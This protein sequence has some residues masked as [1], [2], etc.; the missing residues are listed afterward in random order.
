V[1]KA[2]E[3][4]KE[5]S[6][7]PNG[8]QDFP[9]ELAEQAK[10]ALAAEQ[11]SVD[12]GIEAWKK[13]VQAA[14]AEWP[15]RRELAR[16][17]KQ[18]ERWKNYVDVLSEGVDKGKWDREEDKVPVL[19]EMIEVYRDRLKLTALVAK[20]FDQILTIQPQN[21]EAVDALGA[22]YESIARWPDLI[23]IL[24]RK[25]EVVETPVDK[26]A[27]Y[28]RIANLYLEKFSNQ[29]EAIKA[30]EA[31][32]DLDPSSPEALTYL[33][34][35]YE[36]R[37]DWDKLIKLRQQEI[38]QI[39]DI[40]ERVAALVEVAVLASDK[41]KRASVSI[42]LWEG[43]L[44]VA[45][46]NLEALSQVEKLYEREKTWD[47]LAATL[48]R[49]VN[50]GAPGVDLGALLVKLALLYT[51][52]L[53][54]QPKAVETWQKLIEI[55]PGNRRAQDALKKLYL[56]QRDW[57][58]LEK[59]YA[60]QDRWDEFVRVL[61]RQAEEETGD[62][63][64]S[65][66]IRIAMLYRDRLGK[67]DRAQRA[68]EKAL[69]IEEGNLEA[70]EALI[71]LYEQSNDAGRLAK[72]LEVQ[73][74]HTT[75]PI[76]RQERMLRII[77]IYEG[78]ARDKKSAA[79]VALRAFSEAPDAA[80]T[81]DAAER[82][83]PDVANWQDLAAAYEQQLPRLKGAS[84]QA[85]LTTLA[86]VY[87]KELADA[88]TAIERN[89]KL[90]S[91]APE[92][93]QAVDALQ[94]L[95]IATE[96]YGDLLAIYD[97]K[98]ELARTDEEKREVRF[99][100]ASLYEEEIKDADKAIATYKEILK[101][102]A[103]ETAAL[104]ALDRLY[105]AT[106]RFKDLAAILTKEIDLAE[107]DAVQAD[108][109]YRLGKV[110]EGSLKD[111][112]GAVESFTRALSLDAG[113]EGARRALE[114]YLDDAGHQAAAVAALESIYDR[115]QDLA[116]LVQVQRIKLAREKTRSERVSLHLR[117]GALED[118]LQRSDASFEAYAMAFEEEPRSAAART[119]LEELAS[120]LGRWD[121]VVALYGD[122]LAAG[123]LP[124]A[125]ERELL[126]TLGDAYERQL[127]QS[128]KAAEYFRRAQELAPA[129]ASAL[130]ALERLYTRTERWPELVETLRKKAELVTD[131]D[132][133][134][135]LHVRVATIAEEMIQDLD[136]A[137][138][139][140]KDVIGDNPANLIALR[141]LDRL[142]GAK[143]LDTEQADNL[144]RQ[145]DLASDPEDVVGLLSRLGQLREQRLRDVNA[146]VETY[147]RLL[148]IEP[149]HPDTVAAL[150]R[151]LPN[152][153]HELALA[154]MLEPV[155]KARSDFANLVRVV[156]IQIKYT[157]DA[158]RKLERLHEIATCFEEGLDDPANAYEALA[159]ALAEDPLETE[160][161]SRI[162]R[163]ARVLGQFPD[164]IERYRHLVESVTDRELKRAL[165]HKIAQLASYEVGRDDLAAEAYL[166]AIAASPHDVQAADA[167]INI[168]TRG[169]DYAALVDA[170]KRKMDM[171]ESPAARKELGF[172]AAQIYE[173]V[174]ENPDEAI[175]VFRHILSIDDSDRTTLE[176][177]Q[178]LYI[179]LDRWNDL[180]DI[181]GRM[182]EL[183]HDP[184]ERK[185][186]L[187][188]LGQVYDQELKDPERA[189]EVYS[190]VL[191]AD[192]DD[193]E[194]LQALDRLYAQTRRWFD[195]LAVLEKQTELSSSSGEIVSLRYRIGEL[196]RTELKDLAR[197][198]EA[199]RQVLGM[200]P[201]HEQTLAALENMMASGAEPILA[202]EVLE[203]IFET[204]GEWDRVVAV[205]EVMV[206]HTSD[207]RRKLELL[208]KIAELQER[209]LNNFD[210]AF[211]AH[212]RALQVDPTST[213]TVAHLDRL[214]EVTGR[215]ADLATLYESEMD[216]LMDARAQVETLMRVAR[217]YEEETREDA[218]A[219]A[220]FRRASEIEPE[221]RE[222][223]EALDRLYSK[224]QNWSDLSDVLRREIR[225]ANTEEE[226]ISFTFRLAQVLEVALADLPGAVG[227]YQD[228]LN[229]D[230]AHPETR[231]ALERM[232]HGGTMQGQIAEILEPL[233]RLG[234]EWE[235]L[236]DLYQL[237]LGRLTDTQERLTL[238][239]RLADIAENRLYDQVGAFEWWS[240]LV[241]EDASSE[242]S[243]EQLL[244]LT[245]GTHQWEQYVSTMLEAATSQK[246]AGVRRTVLLQLAATFETDLGN[247]QQAEEVL[248]QILGDNPEDPAALEFLDRIY[249][250]QG[251]FDQLSEILRRRI[252]I[253]EDTRELVALNLRL[254]KVLGEVLDDHDGA[255]AAYQ[256]VLE[257][258]SR[259]S[260]ALEALERLYLRAEKWDD[261]Y[262]IYE[263]MVDIAP[264]DRALADCY[265][266]MATITA[267]VVE[268]RL[269]AIELWQRVLDLRGPDLV[270]LTNLADLH[271]AAG[272]WR[273][274]TDILDGQI[275]LTDDPDVKIPLFKRLGRIW[276]EHLGRERNALEC[277][278]SVLEMDPSD[279]ESLR[280][281]AANYRSAG[282]WE[283]LSDTLRRL[284]YLGPDALGGDELK[285]LYAQLGELEGTTLM[286]TDAAIEAWRS[287]LE[288]D[289][290]DFRALA[291][292][293]TLYTQ[294]ARWEDCVDVLERR[295]AVLSR[296]E[297]QVDVLM[298]AAATWANRIGDSGAAAG[299]YERILQIDAGNGNASSELEQIYRQREDWSALIDLLLTR[300]QYVAERRD[301]IE[302]LCTIAEIYEQQMR[303]KD[304]AY[305]TLTAAFEEDYSNDHV[306]KE[307]ER[308][309]TEAGKWNELIG[310]YT[311][312][313]QG[314]PPA[315]AADL[316]VKIARWWDSALSNVQSAIQTAHY[317]LQLD[318]DNTGALSAL[319]DFYKKLN[320]WSEYV[321]V[322]HRHAEVEKDSD[323]RVGV[324]LALAQ[325]YESHL[326]DAAQA[327]AAYE[328]ALAADDRCMP[329]IDAL[330]RL[331][332]RLNAWDRLVEVLA[333][334]A[335][336][337]DDGDISVKLLLQVGELWARRLGDNGRAVEAYREVLNVDPQS[338]TA[339][340]ALEAIYRE[341]NQ[342]EAQLD[343]IE[344]KLE[345]TE[346]DE[347]R[348]GL[349]QKMAEMWEQEFGKPERA[350]DCLQKI[351]LVD[352]SHEQAYRDLERLYR[353]EKRWE[354]LVEN[355]RR[356][357]LVSKDADERVDL[358]FKL[359]K[360]YEGEIREFDRAIE[361]YNDVVSLNT[362][363]V[364]ALS[365]LARLYEETE[366][367]DRAVDTMQRIVD[368][369][370]GKER[371]DLNYR[372]GKIYD[373]Q[374]R[375]PEAAE[376]RLTEALGQ[377]PAHL[378]SMLA[379]LNLYKTRGDSLK[380]AQL[381]VRAEEHTNNALEKTRLL[382]EAGKLF[383]HKLGDVDQ[384]AELYARTIK[385][386]PEHAEA[387]EP[388]AEIY[389]ARERWE[390]LVPLLE[391][392]ARK[393]DRR[394]ARELHP[395]Y[396]RLAR[397]CDELHQDD[398]ALKYYKQAYD[399]DS[400]HLPT[401]VGR[402]NLLYRRSAWD[403]AFKL[404]QTI[405]VHHREAQGDDEIVEIFHRIGRIKQ[406]VNER[407]K[408]INMFEKALEIAPGHKP[409]LQA[410]VEVYAASN[411]WEQVVKQKRAL[412]AH[413]DGDD[414]RL[415]LL[416]EIIDTYREKLKNPQ[417]AIAS[418]LE[419]L[420]IQPKST[421][422]LHKVLEL[423]I[424]TEQ[425]KRA[426]EITLRLAELESGKIKAKYLEAA[427]NFTRDKLNAPDEAIELYNQALDEDPDNLKVFERI[428]KV[429]TQK[430][431]WKNQAR[432]YRRMIKRLG[433]EVPPEKKATQIALWAALG[434]VYRSRLKSYPEAISAFEVSAGLEP[435]NLQRRHYLAELYQL[436]GPENY[437][438][439]VR[440]HRFIIGKTPD[441]TQT[442]PQLKILRKLYSELGQ[443]DRA[444]CVTA[445]LAFMRAADAEEVRFFELYKPKTLAKARARL[446][447]ELWQRNI[448]HANEDRFVSQILGS[449]SGTV[450]MMRAEPMKK[451][452]LKVN[453][454]RDVAADPLLFSRVFN[455]V[456]QV[457][458]VQPPK[459][460]LRENV[461][462]EMDFYPLTEKN[463]FIPTLVVGGLL[464]S[465]RS[466][467]ELAF[468]LG[469]RIAMLRPDHLVRWPRVVETVSQL[470][471][472]VLAT[473][474]FVRP[475]IPVPEQIAGALPQL[476]PVL[477]AVPGQAREQL[478]V[479]VQRLFATKTDINVSRWAHA[480][481]LTATRAGFLM[482][483]D[484]ETAA[485][486]VQ[487]EPMTVGMADPKEKIRDLIQWSISDEYFTLREQLGMTIG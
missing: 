414:A 80:W 326:G 175:A 278:Q 276:G 329:A 21:L 438:K 241:L 244:R 179:R 349:Y 109:V 38:A 161:Q 32:L 306:A 49:Q 451:Y 325:A 22:H 58:A 377:D 322:L 12:K 192:P 146:A 72:V 419:A 2:K 171:V 162:E 113:H 307:L 357:I 3:P 121:A 83:A 371:V 358:Y 91:L 337:V 297:E 5:S 26:V 245:R 151:L 124:T 52:K 16:V 374:M 142:F 356:H 36:K 227:C 188:V 417:K 435:D 336:I 392:L 264:G 378:P 55:D 348:I 426:V 137:I 187:Y 421:A 132:E 89:K 486:L 282:A 458:G 343:I 388:L 130:D 462:H 285:E 180:K 186:N 135:Q 206:E 376:E 97:K 173:E 205:Y 59:F 129:D 296:P 138:A 159:R 155:Y 61:E 362:D 447:E 123:G 101:E 290:A 269:R 90:L 471:T 24:R 320:Q 456:S 73:L 17:Y 373:E 368:V 311:Q 389:F 316:W 253:T 120:T 279:I 211:E 87:E 463:E 148:D 464:L 345:V 476:A 117:I 257:H 436:T 88:D 230:P 430:K 262:K 390:P 381:M 273:E 286:R 333:K 40:D 4:N 56:Q 391:M 477:N 484:L 266:R 156:E 469:R 233:Y 384:A 185:Q 126:L 122:A 487:S 383:Q 28:L 351:L 11:E 15:P 423:F 387:A 139:A 466:E 39:R 298:Q 115:T 397:A 70:A 411:E 77:E 164:L 82:L 96:R 482:C 140:W 272:E 79:A 424:E 141:S 74:G 429:L 420:E 147:R 18:A 193:F 375:M 110:K 444:W 255:V 221:Q 178:R 153:K 292:L 342:T 234:E 41:L 379:L 347:A 460:F 472:L 172:K 403:D 183:A 42:E 246:E 328:K 300:T 308:L 283:E 422:L 275:R 446:T 145:L 271:E 327:T 249:D 485:R 48:D 213:E 259:S 254:G 319:A 167:L 468:T 452:G 248:V 350:I 289:A 302:I 448:Y 14:P 35:M 127:G 218:K 29:A 220:A 75:D 116:R 261:L 169:S 478:G 393:Q 263:T 280:A 84:A 76:I 60:S 475:E 301:R 238:L 407:H 293:E 152:P 195:L 309:A 81:R 459:V 198:S 217:I 50:L 57:M 321:G 128:D 295:A 284:I 281:I 158:R 312:T 239:R 440:E 252:A 168:Y 235:K 62:G 338:M 20:K 69:S 191:D 335:H 334:K 144:Q 370:H 228:I 372:L 160:T 112:E 226:I 332:R 157:D 442:T 199:Y 483:N 204:A 208:G 197:A 361:A 177:L 405:L 232:L 465:E 229:A 216:N 396:F 209:R 184:Q 71:P 242:E 413:S 43:V 299:V 461:Q 8:V 196:W 455:Y 315:T 450:A 291:A 237:E 479:V 94:R 108:L 210:A 445:A 330:E 453:Q 102:D 365:A 85:V 354:D 352:E 360:I 457:L 267:K 215:W 65:L 23:S 25:A 53:D 64:V 44:V 274:L 398:K 93:E 416:Q 305:T 406:Q 303:D 10:A 287:V 437:E 66:H 143:G 394:P 467:K 190:S 27:L 46:D 13:V 225:L 181:Y 473:M 231:A 318:A 339:L 105:S 31:A 100:L 470:T 165:Y 212:A 344:H 340:E 364:E 176:N 410:L 256:A 363:H 174:L 353:V 107:G 324:L 67:A 366:E 114:A 92:N 166:N 433:Q 323:K 385:L 45:P 207:V 258:E 106:G 103:T 125:L 194:A 355:Y 247:L 104:Q 439:A 78:A 6:T 367:W 418:Y 202:A 431:D 314:L 441:I 427:G 399:L 68:Y 359:G 454:A 200:D 219:I 432:M 223:L 380:A 51:E 481:D 270:A 222:S 54:N 37:R 154:E 288:L 409:T 402:A 401:L 382:F 265:A 170:Y 443:F 189:I 99:R 310:T 214:A 1:G 404:Y 118:A 224:A 236:V 480:V 331:Y 98:L 182:A 150:E 19:W 240:K 149:G 268:D 251:T 313:A 294:E 428:D 277:W 30:F 111:R 434:E 163:L 9:A 136:E 317:A 400:T 304:A 260:E 203:P 346:G 474:K 250:T 34:Q 425:W 369:V 386:D 243:L 415:A 133:R 449:I 95:Y 63:R 33:K 395:L 86:R 47:K 412:L 131:A 119:A 134:E 341:T 7:Q 408:A 201:S